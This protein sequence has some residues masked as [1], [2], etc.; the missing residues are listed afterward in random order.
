MEGGVALFRNNV[1]YCLK[2]EGTV[3]GVEFL[4]EGSGTGCTAEGYQKGKFISK[5]GKLPISWAAIS[6]A[7]GY[8]FKCFAKYPNGIPHYFQESMPE[9]YTQER[10]ITFENDGVVTI[11]H[12]LTYKN[13]V[14]MNH[15]KLTAEG[16]R[17]DSP[18]INDGIGNLLPSADASFPWKNG[19][20]NLVAFIYPL[21]N[22][23][24]GGEK[25]VVSHADTFQ[26]CHT[27][28]R[29]VKV[30]GYHCL[31][32]HLEQFT[33]VDD[34]RHHVV[35]HEFLVACDENLIGKGALKKE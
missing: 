10:T 30:A 12:E 13:G 26:F 21:K 16:F 1:P 7:L 17:S 23:V 14:V 20:R 15:A 31:K 24:E 27:K 34:K 29:T 3:H 33:D 35:Q 4:V 22:P 5:S 9:G 19:M 6:S 18:V 32:V 8:G 11:R 28:N 25:F 2:L